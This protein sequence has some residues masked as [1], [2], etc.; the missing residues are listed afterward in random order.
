MAR[1]TKVALLVLVVTGIAAWQL[2]RDS[3]PALE[4][5]F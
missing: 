5:P 4:A 3:G 1:L 2:N